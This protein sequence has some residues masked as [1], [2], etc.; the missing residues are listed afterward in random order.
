MT[1]R[2]PI[3]NEEAL[4]TITFEKPKAN[5]QEIIAALEEAIVVEKARL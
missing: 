1:F 2:Y 4:V 5:L 3:Q